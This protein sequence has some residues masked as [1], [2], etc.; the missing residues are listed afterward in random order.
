M[1]GGVPVGSAPHLRS[2]VPRPA[3]L[4]RFVFRVYRM[5]QRL[6]VLGPFYE[7]SLFLLVVFVQVVDAIYPTLDMV[8]DRFRMLSPPARPP[9][10]SS[11]PGRSI[12][13]PERLSFPWIRTSSAAP[14]LIAWDLHL[15]GSPPLNSNHFNLP[16]YLL[17]P[18]PT[19]SPTK[20]SHPR[21]RS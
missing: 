19:T 9:S 21:P 20:N 14:P 3:D 7:C 10:G 1:P 15:I 6:D 18:L 5:N 17:L 16:Q 11:P 12:L 4:L 8:K 2:R 13:R